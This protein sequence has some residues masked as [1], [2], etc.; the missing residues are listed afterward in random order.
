MTK[1][2][3]CT[4]RKI[5]IRYSYRGELAPKRPLPTRDF[6]RERIEIHKRE[7][8]EQRLVTEPRQNRDEL[9]PVFLT[10]RK[11]IL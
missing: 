6:G 8:P 3:F 2:K 11:D 1:Y 10:G 7:N 9:A 5:S 4:G